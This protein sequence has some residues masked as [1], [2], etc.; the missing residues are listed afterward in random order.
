[1]RDT[2][3]KEIKSKEDELNKIAKGISPSKLLQS[4]LREIDRITNNE[5]NLHEELFNKKQEFDENSKI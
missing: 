5:K 2:K 3:Y 4:T 1:M